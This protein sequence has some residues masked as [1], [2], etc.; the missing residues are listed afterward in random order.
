MK[1]IFFITLALL[2]TQ[3]FAQSV[4]DYLDKID[5]KLEKDKAYLN[6]FV[7]PWEVSNNENDLLKNIPRTDAREP[8]NYVLSDAYR[9]EIV[10]IKEALDLDSMVILYVNE[11]NTPT[12]AGEGLFTAAGAGGPDTTIALKFKDMYSLKKNRP[13]VYDA[14][15]EMVKKYVLLTGEENIQDILRIDPDED[16][17]TSLGL[18]SRDN[19]DYLRYMRANT[20]S[21]WYPKEQEK[22]SGRGRGRG[23]EEVVS[24]PYRVGVSFSSL[25]FSHAEWMKFGK[26]GG[27]SLELTM[28]EKVVN[29]LP[30]QS[31]RLGVGF[32][33]LFSMNQEGGPNNSDFIDANFMAR[34]NL[35]SDF[36]LDGKWQ[37][38][39]NPVIFSDGPR[40]NFASGLSGDITLTRPFTLPFLN[41]YF[42]VSDQDV[43]SPNVM[44]SGNNKF[45]RGGS[46]AYFTFNQL[47]TTMS[48]FWNT[49]DDFTGR[50][51]MD[52]GLGYYD[53]WRAYYIGGNTAGKEL[54]QDKFAPIIAISYN[55][56]PIGS[57][58]LF[59]TSLKMFDS[60]I[61]VKGWIKLVEFSG[62]KFRFE[63]LYQTAP[64]ARQ[65][66]DW[67]VDGGFLVQLRYRYGL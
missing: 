62:H 28:D 32:R 54:V 50:L 45:N 15:Y 63:T 3:L 20:F 12:A 51:K 25:S 11:I 39:N 36:F 48:F 47:E 43:S 19:T 7:V 1:K 42:S 29:V 22:T 67:E 56:V 37:F 44:L 60:Q 55:F 14:F 66:R 6:L 34:I 13:E 10:F 61:K 17:K 31:M 26:I 8:F 30:W 35:P 65:L 41:L 9:Y 53:V 33:L 21:H 46:Y 23:T 49:S 5:L 38:Q 4:E 57:E 59:G 24:S 18:S 52:I 27:A 16:I 40:L 58:P 64:V 2:T